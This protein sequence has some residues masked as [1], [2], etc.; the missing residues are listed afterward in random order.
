[1][2]LHCKNNVM[3]HAYLIFFGTN[4]YSVPKNYTTNRNIVFVKKNMNILVINGCWL[5]NDI[6]CHKQQISVEI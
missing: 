3:F 5:S 1:M 2:D 6:Q 4:Y